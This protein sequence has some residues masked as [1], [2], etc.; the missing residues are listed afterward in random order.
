MSEPVPVSKKY[1]E[2]VNLEGLYFNEGNVVKQD[3]QNGK[4]NIIAICVNGAIAK[5]MTSG[6]NLLNDNKRRS[7]LE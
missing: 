4:S 7:E 1:I 3:L 6:L 5:D 2:I